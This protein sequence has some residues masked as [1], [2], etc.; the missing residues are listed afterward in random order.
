[1]RA[2]F[3]EKISLMFFQV[4]HRC[5]AVGSLRLAEASPGI[6]RPRRGRSQEPLVRSKVLAAVE[7][8]SGLSF[9]GKMFF[10]SFR[11]R[12]QKNKIYQI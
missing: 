4:E 5:F 3:G 9:F 11:C 6:L 2:F 10:Y 1:M 12:I 7:M 8:Q